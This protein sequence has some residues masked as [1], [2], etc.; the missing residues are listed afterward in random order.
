M[1]NKKYTEPGRYVVQLENPKWEKLEP[2]NGDETR[3]ALVLECFRQDEAGDDYL[4]YFRIYF[5][6]QIITGGQNKGRKLFDLSAEHCIELGMSEPFSPSK[7]NELEGTLAEL[8]MEW[9]EYKGEKRLIGKYLNP[10]RKAALSNQDAES[11]WA[12][13]TGKPVAKSAKPADDDL[14]M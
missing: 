6:G 9:D 3:M 8:V 13:M 5:T 4:E 10:K 11:I 14:I 7:I 1:G 12:K 2:K